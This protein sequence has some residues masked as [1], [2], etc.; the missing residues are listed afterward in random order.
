M[1]WSQNGCYKDVYVYYIYNIYIISCIDRYV[2]VR[3]CI[4]IYIVYIYIYIT[5]IISIEY[6]LIFRI[7]RPLRPLHWALPACSTS[8]KA[9]SKLSVM[10]WLKASVLTP[11]IF[12]GKS[13][14][15]TWEDLHF[16]GKMWKKNIMYIDSIQQVH[17]SSIYW[18]R[19]FSSGSILTMLKYQRIARSL[20][21]SELQTWEN[22]QV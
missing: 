8:S 3:V 22:V 17:N 10:H 18:N 14:G 13:H 20:E 12:M 19:S 2:Y 21:N 1:K 15:K 4:Y 6:L 7:F 5:Y 11:V 9:T 16:D